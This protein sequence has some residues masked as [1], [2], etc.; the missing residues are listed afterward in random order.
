MYSMYEKIMN[1]PLFKGM[2][3]EAIN[4]FAAKTPLSFS[5][6]KEGEV[7]LNQDTVCNTVKCL[8]SGEVQKTTCLFNNQIEISEKLKDGIVIGIEHLFG[9]NTRYGF[10]VR[11]LNDCSIMEFSKKIFFHWLQTDKII[12]VNYLNY[13]SLA[14][15][16]DVDIIK[17]SEVN[18]TEML[19]KVVIDM[20]KN[21]KAQDVSFKL[22]DFNIK[23]KIS[24]SL[25]FLVSKRIINQISTDT[26]QII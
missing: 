6:F 9:L 13:L 4:Q 7:I 10:T 5:K 22:I 14:A 17:S 2:S 16:K 20:I 1:L 21:K 11:A 24:S 12:L 15:Q 25:E 8:M 3:F 18:N 19:L 23:N 26:Y